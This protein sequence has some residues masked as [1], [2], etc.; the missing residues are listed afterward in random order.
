MSTTEIY[1]HYFNG[2]IITKELRK[3]IYQNNSLGIYQENDYFCITTLGGYGVASHFRDIEVAKSV[4]DDLS[5]LP[6]LNTY[7]SRERKLHA[8]IYRK[9]SNAAEFA[10]NCTNEPL[11]FKQLFENTLKLDFF[12]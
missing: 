8:S 2:E 12:D 7:F 3:L 6:E 1:I 11:E 9:Y 5:I 10:Y 4:A